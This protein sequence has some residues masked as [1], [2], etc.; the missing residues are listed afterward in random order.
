MHA[1]VGPPSSLHAGAGAEQR[2]PRHVASHQ[3]HTNH[4]APARSNY[5]CYRALVMSAFR[6]FYPHQ[7]I[8]TSILKWLHIFPSAWGLCTVSCC[9]VLDPRRHWA[10]AALEGTVSIVE[11]RSRG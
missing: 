8:F 2:A 11:Y 3:A 7:A 6:L 10:G 4:P 5:V 1:R 9:A